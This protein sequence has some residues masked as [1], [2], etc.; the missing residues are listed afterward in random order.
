MERLRT[1]REDF[2]YLHFPREGGT[3]NHAGPRGEELG[4][5]L[6]AEIRVRGKP[7]PDILLRFL[8]KDKERQSR[9]LE[10]SHLNNSGGL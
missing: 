1:L 9:S 6:E 8:Q 2:C 3:S 4:F 5:D 10:S 7:R